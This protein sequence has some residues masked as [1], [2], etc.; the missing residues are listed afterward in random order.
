MAW[1]CSRCHPVPR[2]GH[3]LR[4]P[5]ARIPPK[6][7]LGRPC[8]ASLEGHP[9]GSR[10]EPEWRR[11]HC[12]PVFPRSVGRPP[13]TTKPAQGEGEVRQCLACIDHESALLDS[14]QRLLGVN[15][16]LWPTELSAV[17]AEFYMEPT[18][19]WRTSCSKA[20]IARFLASWG[21]F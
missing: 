19:D 7:I 2:P 13:K 15:E 4:Q 6:W 14:N 10:P 18:S 8:L 17:K 11:G 5:P 3:T 20:K 1:W 21:P 9:I 16:P 12:L